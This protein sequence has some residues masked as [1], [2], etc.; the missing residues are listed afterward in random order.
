MKLLQFFFKKRIKIIDQNWELLF[1]TNKLLKPPS[2]GELIY[3]R[4][5]NKYYVIHNFI[6]DISNNTLVIICYEFNEKNQT[7]N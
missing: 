5:L 2:Y 7:K 6:H 4:K 1:E 3:I